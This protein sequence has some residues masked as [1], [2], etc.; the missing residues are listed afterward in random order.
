MDPESLQD[1]KAA[2]VNLARRSRSRDIREGL[3]PG[4]KGGRDVGPTYTSQLV[5]YVDSLWRPEVAAQYS[6]SLFRAIQS[7]KEIVGKARG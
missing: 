6:D 2:L 1:P 4:D 5:E 3:V 7:L